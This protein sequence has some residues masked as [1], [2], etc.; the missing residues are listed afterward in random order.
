MIYLTYHDIYTE[1]HSWV[2]IDN[3]FHF[4]F[5][6]NSIYLTINFQLYYL[7]YFIEIIIKAKRW[8]SLAYILLRSKVITS[9]RTHHHRLKRSLIIIPLKKK[10][11]F[12]VYWTSSTLL[13]SPVV[14]FY[15]NLYFI[16]C[17]ELA[18]FE[19][20]VWFRNVCFMN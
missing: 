6:K 10:K 15:F 18:L 3:K 5:T 4:F 1:I 16:I 8:D 13:V 19:F 20:F 7:L 14:S 17:L 11:S 9:W 12:I 2:C